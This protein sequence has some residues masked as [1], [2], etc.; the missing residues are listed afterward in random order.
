MFG[1]TVKISCLTA[2]SNLKE[3]RKTSKNQTEQLNQGN[4]VVTLNNVSVKNLSFKKIK[5]LKTII[6]I[7]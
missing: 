1:K 3:D 2:N 4:F 6:R 5:G 7:D